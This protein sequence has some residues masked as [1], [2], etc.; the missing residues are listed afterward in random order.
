MATP[1]TI[2]YLHK[3]IRRRSP[4]S[5]FAETSIMSRDW[6]SIIPR[7]SI[8]SVTS[9]Q[10]MY[11]GWTKLC[12]VLISLYLYSLSSGENNTSRIQMSQITN[13]S[14]EIQNRSKPFSIKERREKNPRGEN[15]I[16]SISLSRLSCLGL[17]KDRHWQRTEIFHCFVV[18]CNRS[19]IV[20]SS[21]LAQA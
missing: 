9:Q 21:S 3:N 2:Y 1:I 19:S 16:I 17:S 20:T 18:S 6:L 7:Q 10:I 13:V 8:Y 11:T 4:I 14:G 5:F 15:N 12:S